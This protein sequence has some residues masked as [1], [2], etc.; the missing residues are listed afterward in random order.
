[1]KKVNGEK[2]GRDELIGRKHEVCKMYGV[3]DGAYFAPMGVFEKTLAASHLEECRR[4][5]GGDAPTF[6]EVDGN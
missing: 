4:F 6:E 3:Y 5:E 2:A 1:M